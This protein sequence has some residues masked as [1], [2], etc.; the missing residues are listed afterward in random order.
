MPSWKWI[1]QPQPDGVEMNHPSLFQI[2]DP[3][4]H[5]FKP[6]SFEVACY[7][8]I[9]N[10]NNL[11]CFCP[12][13]VSLSFC[14]TYVPFNPSRQCF[15]WYNFF[16]TLVSLECIFPGFHLRYVHRPFPNNFFSTFG[17]CWGRMFL[18]L[19]RPSGLIKKIQEEHTIPWKSYWCG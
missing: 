2:S 9:N 13:P 14:T 3:Q 5:V 7:T 8:T 10:W 12:V 18:S 6:L 11:W 16:E 15:C 1:F 17:F 19:P 4:N